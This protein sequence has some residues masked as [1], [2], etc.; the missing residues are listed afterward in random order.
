MYVRFAFVYWY[1]MKSTKC[2]FSIKITK[3][4]DDFKTNGILYWYKRQQFHDF[5]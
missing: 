5:I 1:Q 2:S 3:Y 4:F